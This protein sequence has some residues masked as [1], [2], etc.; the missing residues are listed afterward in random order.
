MRRW[1]LVLAG[2]AFLAAVT[3]A[4]NAGWRPAHIELKDSFSGE[5]CGDIHQIEL[6]LPV[7]SRFRNARIVRPTPGPL[8]AMLPLQGVEVT[9]VAI[10]MKSKTA[11]FVATGCDH[12][13]ASQGLPDIGS[14]AS[15]RV[16]FRVD[17][18][19]FEDP[20]AL[21]ECGT[22]DMFDSRA[23]VSASR[24][25]ECKQAGRVAAAWRD[26]QQRHDFCGSFCGGVRARGFGCSV[27][28]RSGTVHVSCREDKRRVKFAYKS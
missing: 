13:I 17:Y 11:V 22:L 21:R 7:H 20:N 4:A 16:T 25:V 15:Q 26:Y 8:P 24:I 23:Q 27:S 9:E 3:P 12:G 10:D 18:E 19:L 6:P 14:W 2:L 28:K 5:G 1:P